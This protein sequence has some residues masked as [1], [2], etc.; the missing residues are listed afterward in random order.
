LKDLFRAGYV[1]LFR[2]GDAL[3]VD[4]ALKGVSE[5]GAWETFDPDSP[6]YY[7]VGITD[8]GERAYD[9]IL[10]RYWPEGVVND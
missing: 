4:A 3:P 5:D 1:E 2:E 8:A 6:H 7:Q 9:E 10:P